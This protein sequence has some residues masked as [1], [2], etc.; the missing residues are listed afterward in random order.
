MQT[1]ALEEI[2]DDSNAVTEIEHA[3]YDRRRTGQRCDLRAWY[4]TA[5]KRRG[6]RKSISLTFKFSQDHWFFH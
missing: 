1:D 4:D 6:Q 2:D 5:H 3:E